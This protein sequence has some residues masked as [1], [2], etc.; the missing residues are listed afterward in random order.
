MTERLWLVSYFAAWLLVFAQALTLVAV[1]SVLGRINMRRSI[2]AHALIT[3]EG[4]PMHELMPLFE[5]HQ[6]DGRPLRLQDYRGKELVALL[7]SPGTVMG[8]YGLTHGAV[9]AADVLAT[10]AR[11]HRYGGLLGDARS[12]YFF[13]VSGGVQLVCAGMLLG[14]LGMQ[15]LGWG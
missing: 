11:P 6:L 2:D 7:V 4:P 14:S 5:G 3:Q 15:W 12:S 9:L 8:L 13:S 10:V 1:L